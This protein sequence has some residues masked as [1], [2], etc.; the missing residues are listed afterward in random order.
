MDAMIVSAVRTPIGALGGNLASLTA[1][2]LAA[3]S[4]RAAL[5]HVPLEGGELDEVILGN[6]VG[7]GIGQNPARQAAV[8]AGI[9][10]EVGKQ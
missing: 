7:A 6:V 3:E 9:P 10:F 8:A 4:I 5:A 1:P 2:Q